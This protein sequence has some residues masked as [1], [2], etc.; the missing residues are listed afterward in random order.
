MKINDSRG[1]AP[2]LFDAAMVAE[3]R[4]RESYE[5]DVVTFLR[6]GEL[7]IVAAIATKLPDVFTGEILTKLDLRRYAQLG[8]GE[9]VVQGRGVE[10]GGRWVHSGRRSGALGSVE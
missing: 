3:K 5:S 4:K 9:Q 1:R 7:S 10:C 2:S 8:A 6:R